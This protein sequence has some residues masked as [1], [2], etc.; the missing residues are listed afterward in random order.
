MTVHCPR[1]KKRSD[2][3]YMSRSAAFQATNYEYT[4]TDDRQC[5]ICQ[6][7]EIFLNR[8]EEN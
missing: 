6:T 3:K 2:T 5:S 4:T 1:S 8:R 7:H